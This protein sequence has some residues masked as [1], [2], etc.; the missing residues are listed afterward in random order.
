MSTALLTVLLALGVN[1][2]VGE[3]ADPQGLEGRGALAAPLLDGQWTVVYIEK[4]G[5]KLG[6]GSGGMVTFRKNMM[7]CNLDGKETN[8]RLEFGPQH[9]LRA[10]AFGEGQGGQP[11]QPERGQA[12]QAQRLEQGQR[13]GAH[14]GVYILSQEYLCIALGQ[15]GAG[16]LGR[17]GV[18]AGTERPGAELGAPGRPVGTGPQQNALVLILRKGQASG[19]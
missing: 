13:Q 9:T 8:F 11:G 2:Q 5:R 17:P 3:R 15:A 14:P 7:S 4:D 10:F 18:G 16:E 12:G 1:P 6:D 19:R